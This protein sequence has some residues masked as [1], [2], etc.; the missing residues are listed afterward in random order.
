M[1]NLIDAPPLPLRI[2]HELDSSWK[3]GTAAIVVPGSH[4]LSLDLA[5]QEAGFFPEAPTLFAI[6]RA[7]S[8]FSFLVIAVDGSARHIVRISAPWLTGQTDLLPF[9]ISDLIAS[10]PSLDFGQVSD[11]YAQAGV[12]SAQ[13]ISVETQVRLGEQLEPLRSADLAYLALFQMVNE[14]GGPGVV[15]HLN[16]MTISSFRRIGMAWHAF[17]GREDLRTP[18]VKEDGTVG[19]DIDYQPVCVP[20]AS[21]EEL[22]GGMA[23]LAPRLYWL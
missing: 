14:R 19:F 2:G 4:P 5:A 22:L 12:D 18:T 15:A 21:N 11:Y 13:F 17:A 3:T 1:A 7:E 8:L 6:P 23:P 16:S 20:V 10:D 9:F